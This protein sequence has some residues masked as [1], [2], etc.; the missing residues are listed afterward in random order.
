MALAQR[1]VGKGARRDR[2]A[3][4]HQRRAVLRR[5]RHH[6]GAVGAVGGRRHQARHRDLRTLCRAADRGHP[7]R[8]VCRAVAR[9]R[10]A[11]PRSS[12][13]SCASG[14]PSSRSR[15]CRRSR[16][17]PRCCWRSIRSMRSRFMLHHGMIGFVT[18]GAVFLAV[19]GAEALYA[20]LGH[21]GK[22]P[23]QTAWLVH[24]AA[25][26]GAELSRAGRARARRS[27]GDREP[28]LPAVSRTGRCSRWS[29]WRRPRP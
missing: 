23:I 7:G 28:V 29:C 16:G 9:H 21:F 22:R 17:I 27:E 4:H 10:A 8:A 5:R 19:T 11:S 26:A 3:R 18:L 15:P 1:A 2:A 20:D 6:A 25:V 14:S 24:R 12:V 13:R